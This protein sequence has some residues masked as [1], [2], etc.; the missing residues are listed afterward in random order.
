MIFISKSMWFFHVLSTITCKNLVLKVLL[1]N[2]LWWC[3]I[4]IVI[5]P[6]ILESENKMLVFRQVNLRETTKVLLEDPC[7][8][9][10]SNIKLMWGYCIQ[11]NIS[12]YL[13]MICSSPDIF[14]K[15]VKSDDDMHIRSIRKNLCP[16]HICSLLVKL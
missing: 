13:C 8:C 9:S 15:D 10:L 7:G 11:N 6:F 12:C 5:K 1:I 4:S 14:E 2:F 16:W 3:K